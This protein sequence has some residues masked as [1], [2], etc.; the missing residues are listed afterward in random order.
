MSAITKSIDMGTN[1]AVLQ[2]LGGTD[3][4]KGATLIKSAQVNIFR[5]IKKRRGYINSIED[6]QYF[7]YPGIYTKDLRKVDDPLL[8]T[9][10]GAYN[11]IY[12]AFAWEQ[13]N[14]EANAFGALDKV[15]W[16]QSGWRVLTDA[17]KTSG[18]GVAENAAIPETT[19]PTVAILSTKPKTIATGFN[20]SALEQELGLAG[21]DDMFDDP[22]A[23]LRDY[24]QREHINLVNRHLLENVTTLAGDNVESID[25]AISSNDEVSNCG[26]VDA[27][28]SD[29][30]GLDRDGG[31]DWHDA[32]VN[33]NSNVDRTLSLAMIDTMFEQ[34]LKYGSPQDRKFIL[35]GYDTLDRIKQLNDP[36]LRYTPGVTPKVRGSVNGIQSLEEGFEIGYPVTMY[37]GIPIIPSD[38]VVKDTIS[39]IYL[40]N[41][42]HLKV[43]T[44]LP[45]QYFQ[46][47]LTTD[48][49]PF[50]INAIADE[51]LFVTMAEM[52]VTRFNS[53][54]KVRDLQ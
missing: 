34:T 5:E 18:G 51:G 12:G 28:D 13:M 36:Q 47:G 49:N 54:A 32:Y 52:I 45:T 15:P 7:A 26:D 48:G 44:L 14:L 9:T 10:T 8:T 4:T 41:A 25:R 17:G 53:Q 50:G 2:T 37:R 11:A 46:T 40:I 29:I 21:G 43:K 33:H 19:K 23:F 27:G 24:T 6:L 39:R 3:L 1:N 35:T 22:I 31:A 42:E 38:N 16:T 20:V 30:Y